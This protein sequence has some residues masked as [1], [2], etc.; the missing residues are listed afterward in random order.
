[1]RKNI[2]VFVI[3]CLSL[4]LS[5]PVFGKDEKR[6]ILLTTVDIPVSYDVIGIVYGRISSNDIKELNDELIRRAGKIN[7]DAVIGVRYLPYLDYLYV[8]GTAVKRKE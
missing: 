3:V 8:Y 4:F 1:M 2:I 6:D 5:L 7:A